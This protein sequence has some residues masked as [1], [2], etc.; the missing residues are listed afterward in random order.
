MLSCSEIQGLPWTQKYEYAIPSDWTCAYEKCHTDT[1]LEKGSAWKACEA[2]GVESANSYI[3]DQCRTAARREEDRLLEDD[4]NRRTGIRV[5]IVSEHDGSMQ[6][7][8]EDGPSLEKAL[9]DF[10][11]NCKGA[12]SAIDLFKSLDTVDNGA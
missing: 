10:F 11:P 4:F 12:I 3:H 7:F 8:S 9:K 2:A 5:Q 6:M 1:A